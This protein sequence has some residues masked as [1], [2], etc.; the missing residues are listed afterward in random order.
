MKAFVHK[1]GAALLAYLLLFSTL[2]FSVDMHFC[3]RSLVDME[4]FHKAEGCGMAMDDSLMEDMGCCSD[5]EIVVIGQDDL[6]APALAV[7][8]SPP[9]LWVPVPAGPFVVLRPEP[10]REAFIPFK[11]YSPPRLTHDL[12]VQLQVFLI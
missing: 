7:V 2:S 10:L 9:D 4:L 5:H 8:L 1:T 12:P 11:E 3:G 6:K